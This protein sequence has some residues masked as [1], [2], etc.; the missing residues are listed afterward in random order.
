VTPEKKGCAF[1]SNPL[2]GLLVWI[3]IGL[4]SV[5][6][7]GQFSVTRSQE[8]R[9]L[10]TARQARGTGIQGRL[11]P[12]LNGQPRLQ[13]PPLAYW[14]ADLSYGLFGTGV[15]SGRLPFVL[16][17][18]LTAGLNYRMAAKHFSRRAGLIAMG[19]VFGCTMGARYGL[20]AETDGLGTLWITAA[21]YSYWSAVNAIP[22]WGRASMWFHA[23]AIATALAILSKGP[24]AGFPFVFFVGLVA[25]RRQ[26]S[27]LWWWVKSGAP[28]TVLA[29]ASP[30]FVYVALGVGLDT[31]F[32]EL[33]VATLGGAHRASFINYFAYLTIGLMPWTAIGIVACIIVTKR[34]RSHR[35]ETVVLLWV[36]A[37]LIPLCCA[38]QKQRHYLLPLAP[39]LMLLVGWVVDRSLRGPRLT[40]P[41]KT[42]EITLLIVSVGLAVFALACPGIGRLT[43]GQ[44]A[45]TDLF[46]ASVAALVAALLWAFRYHGRSTLATLTMAVTASPLL[47]VLYAVWVPSL[48]QASAMS[49]A[50]D[51]DSDFP[52]R[53]RFLVGRADLP[54]QF[55]CR[56]EPVVLH[57]QGQVLAVAKKEPDALFLQSINERGGAMFPPIRSY[58]L[59]SD[60]VHVFQVGR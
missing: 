45:W 13:K 8:A 35:P 33:R 48:V 5:V 21:C 40:L 16:A 24:I 54:L 17:M 4:I 36:L 22:T 3:S 50:S 49:I 41:R 60:S 10:E 7:A 56:G 28:L 31:I 2:L 51:L 27:A 30:W 42:V 18:W 46:A 43:R 57:S 29:L 11:V 55:H 25:V 9:V 26:W 58:L 23:S 52:N 37:I 12:T 19:G 15:F 44:L 32:S 6:S 1:A 39:P 14:L 47:V 53:P 59:E 34:F 38:G 20:L